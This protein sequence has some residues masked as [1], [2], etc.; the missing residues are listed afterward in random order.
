[1]LVA[2][3][4]GKLQNAETGEFD[5]TGISQAPWLWIAVVTV[6]CVVVAV[7]LLIV[8]KK[9]GAGKTENA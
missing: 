5:I 7:A 6:L 1:M 9:M 8:R 4:F 2:A 3:V